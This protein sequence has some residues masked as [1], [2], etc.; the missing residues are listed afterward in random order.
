MLKLKSLEI[1]NFRALEDFK[2]NQLGRINLIVG[3]NNSGK[4][5]ILEALRIYAAHGQRWVLAELAASHNERYRTDN[6]H[7]LTGKGNS[8]LPFESFFTGRRFPEDESGAISIGDGADAEQTLLIKN[9]LRRIEQSNALNGFGNGSMTIKSSVV[10]KADLKNMPADADIRPVLSICKGQRFLPV[11][12]LFDPN[13][14]SRELEQELNPPLPCSVV[15]T[16]AISFDDLAS[17]WDEIGLT[18]DK[19]IVAEALRMVAPEFLD[20]MFVENR[21]RAAGEQL[22][23]IAMVA[24]KNFPVPVPL[25]SM[26]D[27]MLRVLQLVLKLFPAKGG[28]L[29]IDEFE[30]GLHYSVQ[31]K[32]WNLVF[33]FAKKLDIQV[34]ATTHSWDC[35]DSFAQVARQREA[36]EGVLLRVGRSVRTSEKGR[37]GATVFNHEQLFDLTQAKVEVR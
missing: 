4:S 27:G 13:P 28:I 21:E 1:K 20:L 22:S 26:G 25:N 33:D 18:P 17:I 3:K 32:V 16:R 29:L 35:I 36:S 5:S 23:R 31:E 19:A 8:L 11:I 9:E 2:V 37:I 24:L 10:Q 15:P 12:A 6:M 14:V 7:L 30:N 34:F